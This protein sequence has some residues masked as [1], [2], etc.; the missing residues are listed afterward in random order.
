MV[1]NEENWG[2]VSK[3]L[4]LT[5]REYCMKNSLDNMD[6]AKRMGI[7][8]RVLTRLYSKKT[9]SGEV[10]N[11]RL[12]SSLE[13]IYTLTNALEINIT[14]FIRDIDLYVNYDTHKNYLSNNFTKKTINEVITDDLLNISASNDMF[15]ENKNKLYVFLNFA[16]VF[17][18][19]KDETINK[20]I[21]NIKEKN[22]SCIKETKY[23]KEIINFLTRA[24]NELKKKQ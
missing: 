1:F 17:M 18:F 24:E 6:F 22:Y 11:N 10:K 16:Y 21:S 20:I 5:I 19:I 23:R 3:Y 12:L 2:K 4:I 9:Y 8:Q 13:F 14:E 7:N 15:K